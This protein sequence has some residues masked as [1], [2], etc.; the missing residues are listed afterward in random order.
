MEFREYQNP[1]ESD[2]DITS[3]L[4]TSSENN[5]Q[6]QKDY[7]YLLADLIG[8]LKDVEEEEFIEEY[9]ITMQEYLHP[10]KQV[11]LKVKQALMAKQNNITHTSG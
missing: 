10:N 4:K 5:K 11:L 1:E 8:I 6:N 3:S 7:S 9:G 2:Y